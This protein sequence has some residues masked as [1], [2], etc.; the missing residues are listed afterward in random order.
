MQALGALGV[1]HGGNKRII[2]R[3]GGRIWAEAAPNQ[4]ATFYFTL[5]PSPAD[6]SQP[7]KNNTP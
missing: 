5:K 4:G 7:R 3:H 6:R 2:I 1:G